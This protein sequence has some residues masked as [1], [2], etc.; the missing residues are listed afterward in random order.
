MTKCVILSSGFGLNMV[1]GF[2]FIDKFIYEHK[3]INK[4]YVVI[5]RKRLLEYK[6]KIVNEVCYVYDDEIDE[7]NKYIDQNDTLIVI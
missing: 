4:F 6:D 1:L 2:T 3:F 7:L 5:D